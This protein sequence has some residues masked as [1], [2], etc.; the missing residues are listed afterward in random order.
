M[1]SIYS[2]NHDKFIENYMN[3]MDAKALNI[4]R[5]VMLKN[6]MNYIIPAHLSIK[7]TYFLKTLKFPF[8]KAYTDIIKLS[9]ISW[10]FF[11]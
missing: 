2:E 11:T 8:F 3:V 6:K 10:G 1:P 9:S 4:D 5:F 7:V